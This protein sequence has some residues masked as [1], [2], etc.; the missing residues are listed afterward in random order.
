MPLL[1]LNRVRL[2]LR[3][4]VDPTITCQAPQPMGF[5]RQEYWNGLP[6]P[7]PLMPLLESDYQGCFLLNKDVG[8]SH[9]GLYEQDLPCAETKA[10]SLGLRKLTIKVKALVALNFMDRMWSL[11][12]IHSGFFL[13]HRIFYLYNSLWGTALTI[14]S[15]LKDLAM[16][17]ILQKFSKRL[18]LSYLFLEDYTNYH[19]LISCTLHSENETTLMKADIQIFDW[20][21][22]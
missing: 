7:T 17:L 2:F 18:K 22:S 21:L 20:Y 13:D 10:F 3:P 14:S 16:F 9:L 19:L 15:N 4:H 6:F 1:S 11:Q 12:K 5:P 8:K